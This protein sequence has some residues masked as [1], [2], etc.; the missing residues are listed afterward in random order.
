MLDDLFTEP[1]DGAV[2]TLTPTSEVGLM[3]PQYDVIVH[4]VQ[5]YFESVQPQF[6]LLYRP[7]VLEQLYD[8]T[9][10]T[11]EHSPLLLNAMFALASKYTDDPRVHSFDASLLETSLSSDPSSSSD[12]GA[13]MRERWTQGRGFHQQ[14]S[15]IF[16]EKWM[17]FER[18]E[19]ETGISDEPALLLIQGTVLL[20]Y[21]TLTMGAIRQAHRLVST[22]VQ[23]A[24]DA[25]L[26]RVDYTEYLQSS[27]ASQSHSNESDWA[28]SEERRHTWWCI[29]ELD[30]F[31]GSLRCQPW[32]INLSSCRTRLPV[33][34]HDWFDGNRNSSPFL[35]NDIDEWRR[36]EN[37][38]H[39]DSFLAN[40]IVTLRFSMELIKTA[41]DESPDRFLSYLNIEQCVAIWRK[42]LP[43]TL[44][45]EALPWH[46]RQCQHSL[47]EIISTF[48]AIEH[49]R[50]LIVRVQ[51]FGDVNATAAS[52]YCR[53]YS[54]WLSSP[55]KAS[56]EFSESRRFYEAILSSDVICDIVRNW[57][58]HSICRTC[59]LIMFALWAPAC[60]QLMV[61]A[62]ATSTWE[63]REKALISFQ[64]LRSGMEQFAEYW[65]L[66]QAIL[67]SFRRYEDKLS[68]IGC[69]NGRTDI[70]KE[71]LLAKR[72]LSLPDH[73]DNAIINNTNGLGELMDKNETNSD[74]NGPR[75]ILDS[76]VTSNPWH[77]GLHGSYA[78]DVE[79]LGSFCSTF[80]VDDLLGNYF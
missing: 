38:W 47:G 42:R 70:G 13:G 59:P 27:N 44:R 76:V 78:S 51:K 40:R 26:D 8:G 66:G 56:T 45:P 22:C 48:V 35:P 16:H 20:S 71:F 73:I 19:I 10:I 4:L 18:R 37:L 64:A 79:S 54:T 46:L 63:L 80:Y 62:F 50:I 49:I 65:G 75:Q 30:S 43:R 7:S 1:Q 67:Q 57:P 5:V 12:L 24:Y 28:K 53:N 2:D 74:N 31:L 52:D 55:V 33:D 29:W 68:Q 69:T 61:K 15:R 11:L 6:H 17:E 39:S 25:G 23:M 60:I 77:T 41:S 34:D 58:R 14:A 9:L 72:L 3:L 21:A 32:M 36:V